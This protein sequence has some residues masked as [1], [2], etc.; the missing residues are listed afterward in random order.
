MYETWAASTSNEEA[1]RLFR[2]NG[3]EEADHG[4]RLLEAAGLLEG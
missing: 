4:N 3:K 2:L 1:A